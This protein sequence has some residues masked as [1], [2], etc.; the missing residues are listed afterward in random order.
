MAM[1]TNSFPK[2]DVYG[3]N[4]GLSTETA[5]QIPDSELQSYKIGSICGF[6]AWIAYIL[7][8]WAFKGVL[9]FLYTRLT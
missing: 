3:S 6:L 9:V 1:M 2:T 7:A 5:L 8:V 4:I